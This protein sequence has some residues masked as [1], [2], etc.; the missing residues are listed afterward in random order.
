MAITIP[1]GVILLLALILLL[2][3]LVV[4]R[5]RKNK[6]P[7]AAQ[8]NI[9]VLPEERRD[10]ISHAEGGTPMYQPYESVEDSHTYESSTSSSS[11][12]LNG[13]TYEQVRRKCLKGLK[14]CFVSQCV[15]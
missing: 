12:P 14:I 10:V 9:V 8:P 1:I 2:I 13:G 11:R 7:K 3:L 4:R 5:R 6:Q 15:A